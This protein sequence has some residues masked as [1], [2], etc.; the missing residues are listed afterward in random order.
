MEDRRKFERMSSSI[1]VEMRHPAIGLIIGSTMDIS[2]G[3]AHVR[4]DNNVYPPIGTV[5]DVTFKKIVGTI[6]NEPV[7]MKVMHT[8]RTT[9]GLM[10]VPR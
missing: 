4:I 5:M 2:D 9:V 6:N 10:F 3:G 7:A 8:T 1:R